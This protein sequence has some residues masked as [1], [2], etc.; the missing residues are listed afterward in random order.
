MQNENI[1]IDIELLTKAVAG[2]TSQEEQEL[3]DRWLAD[4]EENRKEYNQLLK[5][6]KSLDKT[7]PGQAIDIDAEWKYHQ[8]L[9]ERAETKGK[10]FRLGRIVRFAA[11][12]LIIAGAAV[13][14]IVQFSGN[15]FKTQ[16]AETELITLPDGSVVTLNS[17]SR[18]NYSRKFGTENRQLDLKGEAYFEV[19]P[20]KTKPF[21]LSLIHI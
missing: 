19:M 16:L 10:V 9:L 12:I 8:G 15:T 18:L 4:A 13:F 2:E 21:I 6:W 17:G 20:D 14:G 3:V 7:H 1:H 11:A 5:T